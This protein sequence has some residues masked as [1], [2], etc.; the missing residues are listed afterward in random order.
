MEDLAYDTDVKE[1]QLPRRGYRAPMRCD[2]DISNIK[3]KIPSFQGR[4]DPNA[5]LEWER[6]VELVFDCHHY[7]EEKKVKLVVVE[8]TDYAIV[9]WDQLL[10]S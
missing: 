9:W 5:Y 7:S 1:R 6:K 8:F 3:L 10:V 4:N 2:G